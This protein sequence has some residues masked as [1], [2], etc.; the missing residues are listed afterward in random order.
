MNSLRFR[1][2][3]VWPLLALTARA[4]EPSATAGW[5]DRQ[6]PAFIEKVTDFGER[7]DWSP[8]GR[9]FLFVERSFGDVYEFD[10][11]TRRYRPLTHHFYH[12]GFVRAL[13]LSNGDILLS[14]PADFPGTDW[15]TARF[16]LSELWVL[17][18]SLT[19]PPVRLGQLCWEGP[20]VSRTRLRLAWSQYEGDQPGAGARYRIRV[21]DLDYSSGEPRLVDVRVVLSNDRP[22]IADRVLEP[23]NFIPGREREL[24]VQVSRPCSVYS[25]DV[26]TAALTRH[27]EE[28]DSYNEPEG[29]FPDGQRTLV[30]SSR[31]TGRHAGGDLDLWS[32]RLEPG[33]PD[34]QRVT[35]F[36]VGGKFKASN[37]VVSPDGRYV[38]LQV[39]G[40]DEVAGIGHG[41]YLLDLTRWQ[42]PVPAEK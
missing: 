35:W 38:A 5:T 18:R 1:L 27:V 39:A 2:L 16:K 32:L 31:H 11:A 34:W 3:I 14:G 42:P 12:G 20:A 6:H 25:V 26:E 4:A 29:I 30:E 19:K 28:A 23:Q 13:Y 17:D 22:E 15:R 8:D 10:P 7:A 21:G 36:N 9:K 24:I 41:I 37:P 33:R 40:R